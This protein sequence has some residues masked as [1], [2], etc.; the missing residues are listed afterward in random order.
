MTTETFSVTVNTKEDIVEI[1]VKMPPGYKDSEVRTSHKK[2]TEDWT[3][4]TG[5]LAGVMGFF[6]D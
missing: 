6:E 1:V 3:E 4:T 2:G 5:W